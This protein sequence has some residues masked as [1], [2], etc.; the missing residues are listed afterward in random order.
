MEI[1]V[2]QRLKELRKAKKETQVQIAAAIGVS[3]QYYQ[4]LEYGENYPGIE[5]AWKLADHFG[6]SIDYLVGR[7]EGTM[8]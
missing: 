2:K 7:S 5:N 8:Q 1:L 3:E 4:K 6:V